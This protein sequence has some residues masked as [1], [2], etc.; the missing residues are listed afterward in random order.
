MSSENSQPDLTRFF[1]PRTVAI[2]GATEDTTRFGGRLLR[3]MLKFGFAGRILPVN[4]K[5]KE[6]WG[7]PCFHAIADLPDAPDH[8]GLI[9]PPA[10]VLPV[11]RDCHAL[12]IPFATV[13]TAGFSESGTA[14][15]RAMQDEITRFAHE[16]GMRVMGPNCYGLIN[17]N[18]HFAITASSSLSPEMARQGSIGVV[19]QSGGLGTVNVMWR[20]MQAGLRINF[21]VS[22][23]NEADLDAADFARFMLEHETTEVLM[24]A[25]EGIKDGE[26]FMHLAERAAELEKPIVVLKF[27]RTEAGSR[28]AASHT[29]AMTG[30]DEVFDAACRQFGLIRV[31]DSRDLYETAIALRGGRLPRGRRIAAMSLSGGNV[32]QVADVGSTLGLEW[33]AYSET[34]QEKV[35]QQLPGYGTLSNPTDVTSL[36]SG[37]PDLFRRAMDTI[38]AD[39]HVDVMVP[40]FT[41]PRRA[42]L[43]QAMDL[44]RKSD[45]PLVVLM[46]GACLEDL[47]LTVE[48]MVESGVPAYR[49][50]V[51]CLSA[52]RAAVGYREFLG[53]FRRRASFVRPAGVDTRSAKTHLQAWQHSMLTERASKLVLRAYGIAV[54]REHLAQSGDEAVAH[55]HKLDT[56]IVMK[57][58]SPDIAH[59]TEAGGIRLGLTV[60][61]DIHK[62]YGDIIAAVRRY[63]PDAV[64]DGVL[65]QEMA[66]S[67]VEMIVGVAS[68][69]IFGPVVAVGLGGIH[70]EVLHD[71]AYRIAPL[72][73]AEAIAMLQELHAYK[74][75]E[76][77]RGQPRRD[78]EAV[79][80][81]VVRLSW[82][83]HDF[84]DQIAEIDVNPLMAYQRGVLALDALVIKTTHGRS[85]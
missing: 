48:S 82:L 25:L 2:V 72:D 49:D 70:A 46:T 74:L 16:S 40:V 18:D 35:S 14:E 21:S 50:V 43:E 1:S 7:M 56:P 79:A 20:A 8:V 34:T 41:F 15:G 29:G 62:A 36:A 17:F 24:M 71:V 45:K 33:P 12:G 85:K 63:A 73:I 68:D 58:E 75:L 23:G 66:G 26:K 32:V 13:F 83:A 65:V 78:I 54:T 4:P 76:G 59:K 22:S 69:P 53:Q 39:E 37:Q 28:A 57:I 61:A 38:S 52:V 47:S 55:A 44:S 51:T 31:N 3:Q 60:D 5:R 19:S 27:G 42:E 84:R 67:G 81:T 77:V 11:L 30:A 9:V 10:Q 80:D 6:I 64:I